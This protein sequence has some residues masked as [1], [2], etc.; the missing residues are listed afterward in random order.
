MKVVLLEKNDF[1][2][3]H[4]FFDNDRAG[5][6]AKTTLLEFCPNPSAINIQTFFEGFDDVNEYWVKNE[7]KKK[8]KDESDTSK[9]K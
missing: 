4:T 8:V 7:L 2:L 3:I 9:K 1:E 6:N 5:E